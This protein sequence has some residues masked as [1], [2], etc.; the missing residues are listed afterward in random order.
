V[1]VNGGAWYR[2][3]GT[4]SWSAWAKL[5]PGDN[6]VEACACDSAGQ[7]GQIVA[8]TV[9]A[10]GDLRP[11]TWIT[12]PLDGGSQRAAS[13]CVSGTVW[14]DG[15]LEKV[16]V[17]V[18]GGAWYR[19]DGETAWSA[20]ADLESGPNLIEACAYDGAQWSDIVALNITGVGDLVPVVRFTSPAGGTTVAS[21]TIEVSGVGY[22][23]RALTKVIVR[24]ND[25]AW[26]R[27][28]G[29]AS[30]SETLQLAEGTNVIQA[31]GYDNAKQ[32][33]P[34]VSITVT[35]SGG[36]ALALSSLTAQPGPVGAQ[37]V[38]ALS[39]S[40][41]V[42]A[43]VMNIAGR[44]IRTLVT[45]RAMPAGVNELWWDGRS[46]TG[47]SV[48]GGTYLVRLT[49]RDATGAQCSAITTLQVMR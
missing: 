2:A 49:A 44:P 37:V 4:D 27:A 1:R 19:A 33:G 10:Q 26:M 42:T 7:W 16:I 36:Y 15:S 22:D 9:V 18:N 32:W 43:E 25:G 48:P 38:F 47:L 14:D 35:R 46:S 39:A 29:T 6:V 5:R 30:W 45:D 12:S 13:A 24:V 23:D 34:I 41:A 21:D 17:R 20:W 3:S 31:R 28:H 11:V 8:S 40:G